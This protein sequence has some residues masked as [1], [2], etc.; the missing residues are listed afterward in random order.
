M[1]TMLRRLIGEDIDLAWMLEAGLWPV[2]MDPAQIDQILANLCVNARDAITGSGKITIETRTIHLD[3]ADCLGHHQFRPGDFVLL[4]LSD[5]GSD[6][7]QR[8]LE[9]LFEPFF[10]TKDVDKGTGLGLAMVYGIVKQNNGFYH[11][12]Q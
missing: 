7:D 5:N 4:T 9:N 2:K 3:E 12:R 11:R 6:M 1:L 10:T 8:T